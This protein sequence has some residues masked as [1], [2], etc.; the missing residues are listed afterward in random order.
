MAWRWFGPVA[1]AGPSAAGVAMSAFVALGKPA[2][3]QEE[4]VMVPLIWL[5]L[6][7]APEASTILGIEP[8]LHFLYRVMCP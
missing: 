8:L 3:R 2:T 6:P 5:V 4:T 7:G 1:P